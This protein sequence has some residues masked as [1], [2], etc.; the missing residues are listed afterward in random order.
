MA[1][2]AEVAELAIR[3]APLGLDRNFR[4]YWCASASHCLD[5]AC[6]LRIWHESFSRQGKVPCREA[7][8]QACRVRHQHK[9]AFVDVWMDQA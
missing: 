6:A 7:V 5:L 3:A 2:E 8:L 4:R 9:S 1:Y